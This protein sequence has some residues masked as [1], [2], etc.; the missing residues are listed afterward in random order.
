[1]AVAPSAFVCGAAW[2]RAMW[3]FTVLVLVSVVG[4]LLRF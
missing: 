1:M 3:L 2:A 4:K